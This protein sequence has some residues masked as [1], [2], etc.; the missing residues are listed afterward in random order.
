MEQT[1]E[2]LNPEDHELLERQVQVV[3]DLLIRSGQLPLDETDSDCD[4]LQSILDSQTL[5]PTDTW[6]LQCLGIALGNVMVSV[7]DLHWEMVIDE[8]GRDPCLRWQDTTTVV[9]P[10]TMISKRIEHGETVDVRWLVEETQK[11]LARLRGG[12]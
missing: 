10:L 9:F 7:F 8:Y 3:N 2:K 1:F 12:A 4:L 11:S 6:E 5:L